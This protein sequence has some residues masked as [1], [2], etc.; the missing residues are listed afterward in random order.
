M[1]SPHHKQS[2]GNQES[3]DPGGEMIT[4]PIMKG[5]WSTFVFITYIR[6]SWMAT[7]EKDKTM[8]ATS[9]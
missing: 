6:Y 3:L 4:C 8:M 2:Y 1:S 9:R 7:L 5:D